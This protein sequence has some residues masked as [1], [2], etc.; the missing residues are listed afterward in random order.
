MLCV[1]VEPSLRRR[2]KLAAAASG[3]TI[4]HLAVEALESCVRDIDP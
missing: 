4:Q 1:R 2:V 3:H